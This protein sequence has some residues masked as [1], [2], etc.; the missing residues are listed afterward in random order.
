MYRKGWAHNYR[1]ILPLDTK[2]SII[3]CSCLETLLHQPCE[4]RCSILF[5]K[6]VYQLGWKA[7]LPCLSKWTQTPSPRGPAQ[8][9]RWLPSSASQDTVSALW[10]ALTTSM[11][12]AASSRALPSPHPRHPA[13]CLPDLPWGR[14]WAL[15]TQATSVPWGPSA[16]VEKHKK[17]CSTQVQ[18]FSASPLLTSGGWAILSWAPSHAL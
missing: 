9:Q 13:L 12:S 11:F 14:N 6:C 5:D 10:A 7:L 4:K 3:L 2:K 8:L 16:K 17:S 15:P 18:G 1:N